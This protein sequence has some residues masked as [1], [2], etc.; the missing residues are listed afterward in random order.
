MAIFGGMHQTG[1]MIEGAFDAVVLIAHGA[2][3][4]RWTEPF[5]AM[6][7]LLAE[8]LAPKMVR[9]S[10]MEFSPPPFDEVVAEVHRGGARRILVVPIFLS[11]GGHVANDIPK[12]VEAER[13]R[14]P[15][16]TFLT[17][18]ALGEEPE[19]ATGMLDAVV[20]LAR[21]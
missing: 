14:Y 6:R 3:D 13:S 16:V 12:L 4:S 7:S 17:A 8:R 11:G 5:F 15:E 19:V 1:A 21:G 9:L 18:G 10:F 2:R 20:R